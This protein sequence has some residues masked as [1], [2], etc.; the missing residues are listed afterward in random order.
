MREWQ[1]GKAAL[2]FDY[3]RRTPFV[4]E[5]VRPMDPL[6]GLPLRFLLS[7]LEREIFQDAY[8]TIIEAELAQAGRPCI[9]QYVFSN[10]ELEA[11]MNEAAFRDI[12]ELPYTFEG[13]IRFAEAPEGLTVNGSQVHMSS[14]I[15]PRQ[16]ALLPEPAGLMILRTGNNACTLLS[17]GTPLQYVLTTP[18]ADGK[19]IVLP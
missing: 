14:Q 7:G 5:S 8:N 16:F 6:S 11:L 3:H 10:E 15:L 18:G 2:Y 1:A 17:D 13:R 4:A 19:F 9:T 12:P